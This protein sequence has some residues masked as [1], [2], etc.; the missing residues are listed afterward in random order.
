MLADNMARHCDKTAIVDGATRLSY[1]M[2]QQRIYLAA[3]EFR[4]LGVGP[5][6]VVAFWAPNS[7][8]W[9]VGVLACWWSGCVVAPI[10]ARGRI[11]DAMPILQ[12]TRAKLLVTGSSAVY[13][14]HPSSIELL[15]LQAFGES[16]FPVEPVKPVQVEPSDVCEILFTS[17]SAGEPKGVLRQH[18]QVLRNRWSSSIKRGFTTDDTLLA[19]SEFS[20]TLGLN[21]TLLRSLLLGATLVIPENKNPRELANL[22]HSQGVT[23]ISAAPSLFSS[24]L[25]E[26]I[27]GRPVCGNLR[28]A[29]I[30]SSRIPPELVLQLLEVG[31]DSVASGYGMTECDSI[32]SAALTETAQ[33]IATTVG[34]LEEGFEVQIT[35]DEGLYVPVGSAGEIWIRGYAVSPG[36]LNLSGQSSAV[37]GAD[38]W[39]RSGDIGCWTDDG[40]LRILGRKK[41]VICIHGYTLYPAE[42]ETLLSHSEMLDD[43]AVIGAP[44]VAAG[45]IG[46]AFI[47]PRDTP[48]FSVKDLR[49]W[50]RKHMADYKIPGRFVVVDAL[51]L[52][53][54][55]KV[56][57]QMLR[58]RL[59]A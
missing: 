8:Q 41:E 4:A 18:Q 48:G 43:V 7:W 50:A 6:E 35:D 44:H 30:G 14:D 21:G 54:N 52:G 20:H 31:V 1:G 32:A 11:L 37:A 59:D 33:C 17:G 58:N 53:A 24:L 46:V 22:L 49:L 15:E 57:R 29:S 3:A 47:V 23:A 5:G 34:T 13:G 39:F 45:E 55:G 56:D 25:R 10:P 16:K 27:E 28:L 42:I 9:V 38:G 2:L 12:A 19:I 40:Y 51:P 26:D 36:Y